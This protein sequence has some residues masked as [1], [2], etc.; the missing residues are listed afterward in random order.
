MAAI[1]I[2][3]VT[4]R[5]WVTCRGRCSSTSDPVHGRGAAHRARSFNDKA[6]TGA[7]ECVLH[8]LE[9]PSTGTIEFVT[10]N[11]IEDDDFRLDTRSGFVQ[12]NY[13]VTEKLSLLERGLRYAI[14]GEDGEAGSSAAVQRDDSVRREGESHRLARR[15]Q[16]HLHRRH[17]GLPHRWR[18]GSRPASIRHDRQHHLSSSPSIRRKR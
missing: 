11:F 3:P 17:H 2:R 4:C 13:H 9:E 15:A 7:A 1:F 14:H 16:L 5:R 18:T 12:R 10:N 8:E 6:S